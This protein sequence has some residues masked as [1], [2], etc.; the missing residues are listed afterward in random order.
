MTLITPVFLGLRVITGVKIAPL[1]VKLLTFND[2][3]LDMFIIRTNFCDSFSSYH[4]PQNLQSHHPM[5]PDPPFSTTILSTNASP[6][7]PVG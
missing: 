2:G 4:K 7:S 3:K 6:I 1:P 5:Y